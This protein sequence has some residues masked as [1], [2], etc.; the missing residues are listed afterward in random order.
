MGILKI[1]RFLL[2]AN[3]FLIVW[4]FQFGLLAFYY[5]GITC[6]WEKSIKKIFFFSCHSKKGFSSKNHRMQFFSNEI[7]RCKFLM[8]NI[9]TPIFVRCILKYMEN[10]C[11]HKSTKTKI[12]EKQMIW[13]ENINKCISFRQYVP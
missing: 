6:R 5:S 4:F 2:I 7:W 3:N 12:I 13:N 11:C 10:N 9:H 8:W 1:E